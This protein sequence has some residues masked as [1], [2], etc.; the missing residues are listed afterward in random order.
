M[1]SKGFV[2]FYSAKDDLEALSF[3]KRLTNPLTEE[4][5]SFLCRHSL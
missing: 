1:N 2:Y 4:K 3:E 5:K